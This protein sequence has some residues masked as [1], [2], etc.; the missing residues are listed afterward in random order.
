[1]LLTSYKAQVSTG[2]KTIT[3]AVVKS[4]VCITVIWSQILSALSISSMF[5]VYVSSL[6]P[7]Y[8]Y[9]WGM[10]YLWY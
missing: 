6:S 2:V 10:E 3:S 8:K 9:L 7:T 1:M 5:W 4:V